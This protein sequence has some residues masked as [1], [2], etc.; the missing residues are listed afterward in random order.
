MIRLKKA[1]NSKLRRELVEIADS[2]TA[3][4]DRV[5]IPL[6]QASWNRIALDFQDLGHPPGRSRTKNAMLQAA[7]DVLLRRHEVMF[8]TVYQHQ[9]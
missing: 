4:E 3:R 2:Q 8:L 5:R 6:V 7:C 9:T 1:N